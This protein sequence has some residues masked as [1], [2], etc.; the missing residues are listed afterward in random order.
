MKH[1]RLDRPTEMA[2]LREPE[3]EETLLTGQWSQLGE[4]VEEYMRIIFASETALEETSPWKLRK[5]TTRTI[6][7]V[8]KLLGGE[9][10]E[11][12]A[13]QRSYKRRT[14]HGV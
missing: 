10:A 13:N 7:L 1:S 4:G 5:Q 3:V 11:F 6:K 9:C 12:A 2:A 14:K 8:G